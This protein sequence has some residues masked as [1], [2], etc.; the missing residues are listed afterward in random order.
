MNTKTNRAE[1]TVDDETDDFP[2]QRLRELSPAPA[3]SPVGRV[4]PP[5]YLTGTSVSIE[6]EGPLPAGRGSVD[7]FLELTAIANPHA[8][9]T[10]VPPDPVT[11]RRR[12]T[13][14]LS[15]HQAKPRSR[16]KERPSPIQ[17]RPLPPS[18]SPN[19]R[20]PTETRA[21]GHLPRAVDE[22]PPETKEIQPHP[23]G[24][25]LGILLQ[26]LKDAE[27]RAR[28]P[29]RST[30]FC[31]I[32]SAASPPRP[33]APSA[34]RSASPAAP[35]SPTSTTS[36]PRKTLQG[37]PGGQAPRRRPPTASPP[38]ACAVAR[39]HVQ[40]RAAEFYA[41]SSREPRSTAAALSRSRPPSPSA[42]NSR[43]RLRPRHPLR[44]PRAAALPAVRLLAFKAVTET[45]WRNY[46]LQQ[47]RGAACPSGPWSS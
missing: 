22:L 40:G 4:P 26:M 10:F 1:V 35:R 42:A 44:Q 43:R 11:A 32:S 8:R 46:D 28:R 31:R 6:L 13:M 5:D 23:K 27:P 17:P 19:T 37:V 29:A 47:P 14:F 7:E 39:G 30:T 41:A 16:A 33:P 9:I 3:N 20:S 24:I 25:E 12:K 21:S 15:W 18:H 38:S 2:L 36:R 34:R 45:N